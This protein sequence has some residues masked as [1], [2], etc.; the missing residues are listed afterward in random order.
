MRAAIIVLNAAARSAT[1]MMGLRPIA[2]EIGP[3]NIRPRASVMVDTDKIRLHWAA[4]IENAWESAGII[5]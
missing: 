2:S 1:T 3:V 4:L 5:G